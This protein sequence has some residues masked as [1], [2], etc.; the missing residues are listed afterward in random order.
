[1]HTALVDFSIRVYKQDFNF[2]SAHFLIFDN[3]T[4]EPLHGH[5]YRV[6]LCGRGRRLEQ[7]ML[8]DF[9]DIKPVVRKVCH[10]L[11]HRLL[12]PL[13]N[14]HLTVEPEGDNYLILP[15]DGKRMSLP[16]DDIVLLPISNTSVERLAAYLSRRI[17]D[18]V[19]RDFRFRFR[20]LE[21][22]VEETPGQSASFIVEN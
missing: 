11:D 4:R 1:M 12:L 13:E 9:L 3:G 6:S 8:F 21:V 14:P 2:A 16:K 18:L 5:N 15:P 20:F 22:E 7:D 19:W 10:G 17:G